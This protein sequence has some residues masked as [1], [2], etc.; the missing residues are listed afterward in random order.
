MSTANLPYTSEVATHPPPLRPVPAKAG[1]T[2]DVN[3]VFG[4]GDAVDR[5]WAA[6]VRGQN[7]LLDEPRR[8][9]KTSF[10]ELM[11]TA[12][13]PRWSGRKISLQGRSRVDDVAVALLEAVRAASG[14]RRSF[15]EVISRYVSDVNAGPIT[16]KVGFAERPLDALDHALRAIDAQLTKDHEFL[17]LAVDEVTEVIREV[18]RTEGRGAAK[19]LLGTLRRVREECNRIRWVLT[20]SI[21]FHHVLR[22]IGVTDQALNNLTVFSLGALDPAW[23]MWLSGCVLL[24]EHGNP[25]AEHDGLATELARA[26]DGIPMLIHLVGEFLRDEPRTV[27]IADIAPLLDECFRRIDRSA[28]LTHL[29]TR[30]DDYYGE[31]ADAAGDLLDA[32][33]E[34]PIA[35][36][37]T[38]ER[39]N[40]ELVGMLVADHYLEPLAGGRLQWKY[41]SLARLWR[42]RRYLA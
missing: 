27:A 6:L 26:S 33:S 17:V 29:L 22:E 3:E 32:A 8:F 20:G 12:T 18:G 36:P 37:T 2:L 23:A 10:L 28:N 19:D 41:P 9:G 16:F 7:L 31:R 39:V 35:A 13:P 40:R 15:V 25:R 34:G 42:V 4:R 11:L 21:G 30:L 14:K 38:K 24:D 5:A 1:A